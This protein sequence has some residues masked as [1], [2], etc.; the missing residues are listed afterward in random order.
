MKEGRYVPQKTPHYTGSSYVGFLKEAAKFH[1]ANQEYATHLEAQVKRFNL[2][3]PLK[4]KSNGNR[5]RRSEME[6][7]ATD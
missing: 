3:P 5:F 4:K 6:F 2:E 7:M 1:S